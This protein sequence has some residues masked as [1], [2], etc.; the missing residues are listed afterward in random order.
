[1]REIG[2]NKSHSSSGAQYVTLQKYFSPLRLVLFFCFFNPTH[3]TK[4]GTANVGERPL[5]IAN[6]LD[7]SLCSSR[8]VDCRQWILSGMHTNPSKKLLQQNG[9]CQVSLPDSRVSC[10][11][12]YIPISTPHSSALKAGNAV[13]MMHC[14]RGTLPNAP[15]PRSVRSADRE[16]RRMGSHTYCSLR[17][18]MI[19]HLLIQCVISLPNVPSKY[20]TKVLQVGLSWKNCSSGSPQ[21]LS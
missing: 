5:Q 16:D 3:K 6:H 4:I 10:N 19:L 18:R 7:R 13:G 2:P 1:L 15:A 17:V 11:L 21:E 9:F 8:E 14:T 12:R 20:T